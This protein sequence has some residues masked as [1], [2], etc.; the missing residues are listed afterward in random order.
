[1]SERRAA[2]RATVSTVAQ[3]AGVST[4][5]VSRVMS[6]AGSVSPALAERVRRAAEQVG[7]HPNAAARVLTSG[8]H[9]NVAVVIPDAANPYFL[10]VIKSVLR[11]AAGEGYRTLV[12]D[13]Q[14]DPEEELTIARNLVGTVDGL[15]LLSS[16]IERQGLRELARVDVPV[17]LVNRV[18]LGVEL[19]MIAVDNFT[20]MLS[21]CGHLAELGHRRAV[22]LSGSE[23]A[24]Q[25]RERWRAVQQAAVFG[26]EATEIEAGGSIEAGRSAVERA[27]EQEPTALICFNDLA[28]VGVISR[29]RELGL[30]VPEDVSVTGFDD[31]D[32]ARYTE[33][34]LTTAKSPKTELGRS[35]WAMLEQL[36]VGQQ[37]DAVPLLA[38]EVVIGASTGPANGPR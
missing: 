17:V 2:G 4:A 33:P 22:Y 12:A 18:E 38:A 1:M 7:Y 15:I 26:L 24:W 8:R 16:R 25:N 3:V 35:A 20:A 32:L 36:L 19:P 34:R 27:M 28:A 23:L 9:R 14:G 29:L 11:D 37:V 6:G 10:Q 30:R 21:L 13:S 31:I 5:T